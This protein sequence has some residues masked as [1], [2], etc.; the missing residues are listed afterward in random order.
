MVLNTRYVIHC[1]SEESQVWESDV[2]LYRKAQP[3]CTEQI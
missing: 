3:Y 2:S 1:D